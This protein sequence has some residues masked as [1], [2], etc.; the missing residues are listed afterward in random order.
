MTLNPPA[1]AVGHELD[2]ALPAA[3]RPYGVLLSNAET[4]ENGEPRVEGPFGTFGEALEYAATV[5]LAAGVDTE[6]MRH[7]E[8]GWRSLP[9]EIP[10][11]VVRRR[12]HP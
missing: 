12:W 5:R 1:A 2:H 9:G 4:L 6:I 3:R 10:I 8:D 11:D 7:H